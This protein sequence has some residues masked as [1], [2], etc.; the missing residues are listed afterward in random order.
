MKVAPDK[1]ICAQ[2]HLFVLHNQRHHHCRY[3]LCCG[4]SNLSAS[5]RSVFSNISFRKS[6]TR[7]EA[8][9]TKEDDEEEEERKGGG[10]DSRSVGRDSCVAEEI[11]ITSTS[12]SSAM[13]SSA[14]LS[15]PVLFKLGSAPI[16]AA[17]QDAK[18]S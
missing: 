1:E 18:A 7:S 13:I 15:K 11:R 16:G 4:H 17:A 8:E 12:L 10:S 14:S 5:L 6:N 2:L 3:L 9:A